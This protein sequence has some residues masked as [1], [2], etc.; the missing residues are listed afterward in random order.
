[1]ERPVSDAPTVSSI[2]SQPHPQSR[3]QQLRYSEAPTTS[4]AYTNVSPPDSPNLYGGHQD[5]QGS[6]DISPVDESPETPDNNTPF[7]SRRSSS[8][9]VPLRLQKGG[10]KLLSAWRGKM[11]DPRASERDSTMTRWD[12]FSGEPTTSERGKPA[13]VKPGNAPLSSPKGNLDNQYGNHVSVDGGPLASHVPTIKA[14]KPNKNGSERP[15]GPRDQWKGASGRSAMISPIVQKFRPTTKEIIIPS[16]NVRQLNS[17]QEES[18]GGTT[19]VA[20]AGKAAQSQISVSSSVYDQD[21]TI[22]PIVPLKAGRNSPPRIMISPLTQ[23]SGRSSY[24]SPAPSDSRSPAAWSA[25]SERS[26]NKPLP[27]PTDLTPSN[28]QDGQSAGTVENSF[29]AAMKDMNLHNQPGSRFSATTYAT[30]SYESPPQTPHVGS[31]TPMPDPQSPL[32][33]RKRPLPGA[34]TTSAKATIRKPTP[35]EASSSPTTESSKLSKA[36]PKSPP[37]LQSVDRISS[38]E[39]KLENL[40]RRRLNLQTV[41]RELTQVIQPSTAAYDMA[42]RSEIKK[43][44]EGLNTELAGVIKDEHEVGMKLHRAWKKRDKSDNWEPTGLWVRRVTG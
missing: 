41:I 25:S 44:V 18:S 26:R 10:R 17:S 8:I 24:P 30:T 35:S 43:T 38:L 13:Q 23:Q 37:E 40:H 20:V 9:P 39:A 21:D 34:V 11:E 27:S 29:A 32:L 4:S 33:N 2:Y 6:P 3:Q 16:R 28:K 42:S 5:W 31:E 15:M 22:K 7:N 12:D 19:P 36:L 1:M 14:V